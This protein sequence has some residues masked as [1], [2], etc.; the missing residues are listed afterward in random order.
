MV[1]LQ[2]LAEADGDREILW[3]TH[4]RHLRLQARRTLQRLLNDGDGLPSDA[5]ALFADRFH[6]AMLRDLPE[7]MAARAEH[8]HLVIVDEGHHA[9]APSY[10]PL[11]EAVPSPRALFLTATPNRADGLPIGIDEVAYTV[12]YGELFRRGCVVEPIFDPPLTMDS[13]DWASPDGLHDLADY[14]LDRTEDDLSKVLVVVS[15]I[16]RVEVLHEAIAE[17]HDAR[18]DHP[19]AA[20][21]IGFCHGSRSSGGSNPDSF[22]DAFAARPRGLLV[23]TSQL[24]G[25]GFDDPGID[26]V[27]VTYPSNSISHLMQVAGRA[28]RYSPGKETAHVTQVRHSALEYHF[29]QRWLYQDISDRLRPQ[30]IDLRYDST[31]SLRQRLEELLIEHRVS[32]NVQVR[33]LA[34]QERIGPGETVRVVLAGLPYYGEVADFD[35]SAEWQALLTGADGHERFRHIFN[36]VSDRNVGTH[37]PVTFLSQFLDVDHRG[38]SAWKS[39]HDLILAMEHAQKELDGTPYPG[40]QSRPPTPGQATT[41]LR[42]VTFAYAPAMPRELDDFLLEAENRADIAMSYL[43]APQMWALAVRVPLPLYGYEAFLLDDAEAKWLKE[44]RDSIIELLRASPP[45]DAYSTLAAWR[46]GLAR[47]GIPLRLL[48]RVE[49]L[50]RVDLYDAHI[51]DLRGLRR[52]PIDSSSAADVGGTH[53]QEAQAPAVDRTA[54]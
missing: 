32:G 38:G 30:L 44:N 35:K 5:V 36:L 24:V 10:R 9:A 29:E 27:V 54:T 49:Y 40:R 23:A 12:T 51:L 16:D 8:L 21:D 18:P 22:L 25:E 43:D 53:P 26:G 6:F 20:D 19:L 14:L 46:G 45:L 41:W 11:F 42:Y 7:E 34:E 17:L 3:V 2:L 37:D 52:C 48:D 1:G 4:R 28:L 33:V 13:L 39:Y 31:I 15:R 47:T 50:L